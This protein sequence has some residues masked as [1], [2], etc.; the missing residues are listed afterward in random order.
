MVCFLKDIGADS[1]TF[2]LVIGEEDSSFDY[3]GLD[4]LATTVL[5][6]MSTWFAKLPRRDWAGQPWPKCGELL[7]NSFTC[8]TRNFEDIIP[9]TYRNV[10][11]TIMVENE[12]NTWADGNTGHTTHS[13]RSVDSN[14]VGQQEHYPEDSG[15]PRRNSGSPRRNST[16]SHERPF[17]VQNPNEEDMYEMERIGDPIEQQNRHP[18]DGDQLTVNSTNS[19]ERQLDIQN[20]NEEDMDELEYIG[21]PIGQQ[22]QHSDE[23]DELEHIGDPSG[24]QDHHPDDSNTQHQNFDTNSDGCPLE[25]GDKLEYLEAPIGQCLGHIKRNPSTGRYTLPLLPYVGPTDP[26]S[27]AP[28]QPNDF[29]SWKIFLVRMGKVEGVVEGTEFSAYAPNDTFLCTF[30]AQSVQVA[31][32]IL[33][34]E[35]KGKKPVIIPRGTRVQVSHWKNESMILRVEIPHNF[36]YTADLFE[37]TNANHKRNFERAPSCDEAH[38]RLR[39]DG[40]E[41]VVEPRT[42]IMSKCQQT[43]FRF[44]SNP[45]H[46]P[47]V[48]NGIAH[49]NYF[50]ERCNS[51]ANKLK[52]SVTLEMHRLEGDYPHRQPDRSTGQDGNL[53]RDGRVRIVSEEGAKYGFTILNRSLEQVFPYLF[54]FNPEDYTIRRLYGPVNAH[55]A[56]PLPSLRM[57]TIGMGSEQAFDFALSPGDVS[58][59]G[60]LKLFVATEYINLGWIEQQPPVAM[61]LDDPLG[62]NIVED[63]SPG[64][65]SQKLSP[66][67]PS[68]DGI[69]W[70]GINL[71]LTDPRSCTSREPE[72]EPMSMWDT[73][74]VFLQLTM[75]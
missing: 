15:S 14:P 42:S 59:S 54:Y 61:Q 5:T 18:D 75:Q 22:D 27:Q 19:V 29:D 69:Q 10:E 51:E 65:M 12:D 62:Q 13:R 58:R 25:D 71:N 20:P 37:E 73:S 21:D 60:F 63:T 70:Q 46:L 39:C 11:L 28:L 45:T 66:S 43:R 33:V 41:I 72:D 38:I 23:T 3:D 74:T 32:T 35:T 64:R 31:Q 55:V 52:G 57:V 56:P 24:Q 17:D 7:P 6:G 44:K 53:V 36:P 8:A 30:V 2:E 40:D 50:L 9:T 48:M 67:D 47:D 4:F 1:P 49:F 26:T 68:F 16:N 34:S